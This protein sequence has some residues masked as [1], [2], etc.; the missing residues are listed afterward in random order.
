[1]T[2]PILTPSTDR[3]TAFPIQYPDLWALYKKSVASF[4][5]SEEI[6]LGGDL[7]DW[8]KLSENERHFIKMVLAFF[9][10][11]DGIV[12]ENIN[13][14]FGKTRFRFQRLA[15]SMRTRHSMRLFTLRRIR[16]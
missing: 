14:N 9:A 8:E 5:T 16:L 7:K 15:R 13:M 11:S 2:D 4:W 3:Y 10:A 1:M 6:D 12:M